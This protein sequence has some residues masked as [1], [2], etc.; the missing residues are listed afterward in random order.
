MN[1]K[2]H[3]AKMQYQLNQRFSAV[4]DPAVWACKVFAAGRSYDKEIQSD[5]GP[6]DAAP[7]NQ[8]LQESAF[9]WM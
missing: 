8:W 3:I 5:V 7:R 4:H 2:A 1:S 9:Y 6:A